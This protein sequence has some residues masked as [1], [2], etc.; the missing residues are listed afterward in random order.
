MT[1]SLVKSLFV[2]IQYLRNKVEDLN[3]EIGPYRY[4]YNLEDRTGY[5]YDV[6]EV[7]TGK[8]HS[9]YGNWFGAISQMIKLNDKAGKKAA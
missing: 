3:E 5:A 6:V 7:E 4:R 8:V 2:T 1:L 9:S